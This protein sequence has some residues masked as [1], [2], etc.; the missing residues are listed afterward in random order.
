MIRYMYSMRALSPFDQVAVIV[1][2]RQSDT[3]DPQQ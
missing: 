1:S 2:D 3:P